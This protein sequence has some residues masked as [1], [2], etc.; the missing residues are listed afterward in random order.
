MKKRR[1]SHQPSQEQGQGVPPSPMEPMDEL[2][3]ELLAQDGELGL[4]DAS[5]EPAE[6]QSG[7]ILEAP[8]DEPSM[9]AAEA[10][11]EPVQ[12]A[13]EVDLTALTDDIPEPESISMLEAV[14]EEA[15]STIPAASETTIP[16]ET[17]E[18]PPLEAAV[19][20][21]VEAAGPLPETPVPELPPV[22]ALP[23]QPPIEQVIGGIDE[24]L[25]KAPPVITPA[26]TAAPPVYHKQRSQLDDYVV[27]SLAGADYAVP[28]KDVAEIGRV[29]GIT[30]VPNVPDFV[31]GIT[32][33]RGEIVPVLNLPA[34]LGLEEPAVS[35]RGR[36]LFL[37]GRERVS[38]AGLIVDEVKGIQRIQLQ[39]LD[40]VTG[41]V[42]DKV[43]SVLRGVHGRGDRLLN[44]L[45]LEQLFQLPEFRQLNV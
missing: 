30:R 3:A 8:E 26:E 9:E 42:D 37:Q 16:A 23:S 12:I 33:L 32:N 7:F 45:D 14:L 22:A 10:S 44:V 35:A 43:T 15:G 24:E 5:E 17:I 19:P 39:Q 11:A 21:P 31:R 13:A 18:A 6:A 40:Q 28:V 29:P 20:E 25:E 36:V 27:F 2:L 1:K 38:P 41:L 34:L 4:E